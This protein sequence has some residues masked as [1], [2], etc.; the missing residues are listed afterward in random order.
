MYWLHNF[1][2]WTF[3][4]QSIFAGGRLPL[5]TW[6]SEKSDYGRQHSQIMLLLT[7]SIENIQLE[8]ICNGKYTCDNRDTQ[9]SKCSNCSAVATV[10]TPDVVQHIIPL[11]LLRAYQTSLHFQFWNDHEQKEFSPVWWK[12]NKNSLAQHNSYLLLP[13]SCHKA[14]FATHFNKNPAY[15]GNA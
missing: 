6:N 10:L 5:T 8:E 2:G 9:V 11:I 7:F 4:L 14:P 12:Y 13:G 3:H 15:R 1:W